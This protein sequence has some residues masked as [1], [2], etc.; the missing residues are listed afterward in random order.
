MSH[1]KA[2][3]KFTELILETFRLNGVLIE[4]GDDLIG[5]LGLSSA[6][7]QILGS[8]VDGP[9]TVVDIA[10]QMGLSRQNVQRIANRLNL[11]GF[12]DTSPNP[13]HRRSK[14]YHLTPQGLKT[15]REVSKRQETWVNQLSENININELEKTLSMM[16]D[17]R[18][19][20]QT[21]LEVM[22]HDNDD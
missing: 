7:W 21:T 13:T 8:L 9:L 12:V 10:R 11:D 2:G 14:L 5:D 4:A 22:I 18:K 16:I 19:R 6:R 3:S 20:V 17:C 1:T 15:M